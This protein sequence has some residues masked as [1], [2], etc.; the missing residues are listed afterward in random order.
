MT[1]STPLAR[2]PSDVVALADLLRA[3]GWKMCTAESC[4]GGMIGAACIDLA[5]SSDWFDRGWITYSNT[6]KVEELGVPL[7]DI[8]SEGAV[9]EVV[10]RAMVAGAVTRAKQ[11]VGVAVTGVAG[12]GGGS[13]DKPVGT[14]W[15]AWSVQGQ[16]HAECQRFDG[17]RSAV[18]QAT[19][20]H[21]LRVLRERV[22]AA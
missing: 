1:A 12:P 10:A 4:T 20:A 15:F 7:R 6:A 19:L 2:S 16:V 22:A 17:D 3:K 8:R 5:G 18:R 11:A 13:A 14:V 9:S 21:A